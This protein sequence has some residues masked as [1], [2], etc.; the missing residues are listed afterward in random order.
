[1]RL[2]DFPSPRLTYADLA[3]I[4]R[5][6]PADSAI[7]RSIDPRTAHTNES[8]FLRSIEYSLRW[9]VWSKTKDGSKNRNHPEQV[10]FPWETPKAAF[11]FD[12]MTVEEANA[13]LGW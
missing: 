3:T 12:V 6:A 8:E 2:R 5:Y 9:L 11:E 13:F 4:V 7:A 10:L 1:M